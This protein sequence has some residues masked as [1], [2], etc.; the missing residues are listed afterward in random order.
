M[1]RLAIAAAL[2]LCV[3]VLTGCGS[4][5]D[6]EHL[7]IVTS[8]NVWADVAAQVG[9]DLVEVTSIIGSSGD[10]HSFDASARVQLTLS[11][12]DLVIVNG[13]GYD[14]FATTL[15]DGLTTPPPAVTAVTVFT[16]LHGA[17]DNEHVWY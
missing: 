11:K 7:S 12:A 9:G 4:S 2:L 8:T 15:L 13:G 14:D 5:P 6:D 16:E 17:D 3:R 1:N 10:P